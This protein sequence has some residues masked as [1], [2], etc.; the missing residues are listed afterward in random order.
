MAKETFYFSH[1]YNARSDEKNKKAINEIWLFRI[2]YI[3]G[4]H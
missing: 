4:Y 1:D 2:W 3:L